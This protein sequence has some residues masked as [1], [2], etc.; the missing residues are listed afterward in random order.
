MANAA[1]TPA[2]GGLAMAP[3]SPPPLTAAAKSVNP[4]SNTPVPGADGTTQPT[5]GQH[6]AS[7]IQQSQEAG[8]GGAVSRQGAQEMEALRQ[9]VGGV[10]AGEGW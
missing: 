1:S 5:A 2:W 7:Q 9:Q 4:G 3:L 10:C 6:T 8:A